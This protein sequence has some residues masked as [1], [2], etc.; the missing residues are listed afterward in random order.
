MWP[1][2]PHP[3]PVAV[4]LGRAWRWAVRGT[5]GSFK[6]ASF[7]PDHAL[8]VPFTKLLGS[9]THA[10]HLTVPC[11]SNVMSEFM[12]LIRGVYDAKADGFLPGA[13]ATSSPRLPRRPH[14]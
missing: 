5:L 4:L 3:C 12:G 8:S 11:R 9:S 6:A 13:A 7:P 10:F 2:P 14:A 1:L